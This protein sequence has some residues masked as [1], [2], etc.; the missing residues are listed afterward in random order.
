MKLPDLF[1]KASSGRIK[2]WRVEVLANDDGTA[3]IYTDHGYEGGS[4]QQEEKIIS[5]GKNIG[6]S[7]ETTPYQQSV[8]E[9]KSDFAKKLDQGY[10]EDKSAISDYSEAEKWLPM[11]AK[12]W[13]D[14]KQHAKW[15][16]YCQMKLDGA[17]CLASKQ[18]GIVSMWSRQGKDITV[19][20]KIKEALERVM[21]DGDR[22]DGE[23]YV[24]GWTFQRV[25]SAVKKR[26]ADTDLLEYHIYDMPHE[27]QTY[28]QRFVD[29]DKSRF[30]CQLKIV[31][32]FPVANQA[33]LDKYEEQFVNENYEGLMFRNSSGLYTFKHRSSSL[34]KCKRFTSSEFKIIGGKEGTGRDAGTVIFTI[35]NDDGVTAF[36]ARPAATH[37]ERSLWFNELHSCIGEVVTVKYFGRSEEN[38]PRFPVVVGFRPSWDI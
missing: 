24:H 11:L 23:L 19:P 2:L 10:V 14:A 35:Q 9:A 13:E 16:A 4:I 7:N 28:K 21:V 29:V 8:S 1:G 25:I 31:E 38:I 17:R 22:L 5:E 20:N 36:D 33:E 32:A 27:T 37:E 26:C 30:T 3:S 6:K 18:N 15:P 34:L 12:V